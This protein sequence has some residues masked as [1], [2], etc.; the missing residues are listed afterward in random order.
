MLCVSTAAWADDTVTIEE[1]DYYFKVSGEDGEYQYLSRGGNWGTEAVI[2]EYGIGISVVL[3]SDGST[4]AFRDRDVYLASGNTRGF[5]TGPTSVY[6]DGDGGDG[7]WKFSENEDGTYYIINS[8]NNYVTFATASGTASYGNT[9][10]Y[11]YLSETSNKEDAYCFEL[12][13]EEKYATDLATRLD[14]YAA[15]VAEAAGLEDVSSVSSLETAVTGYNVSDYSSSITNAGYTSSSGWTFEQVNPATYSGTFD[16]SNGAFEIYGAAGKLYQTISD[17]PE[18]LYKVGVNAMQRQF[19]AS[20]YTTYTTLADV[21]DDL[22][23]LYAT[24]SASEYQTQVATWTSYDGYSSVSTIATFVAAAENYG[25]ALYVYVDD[26][27]SLTIGITQPDNS[28]YGAWTIATGWTLTRYTEAASVGSATTSITN[29]DILSAF[30]G[31]VTVKWSAS[32]STASLLSTTATATLTDSEG[33][34]IATGSISAATDGISVSFSDYTLTDY[35]TYTITIPDS[36]YGWSDGDQNTEV[37]VSFVYITTPEGDYYLRT[38]DEDGEYVYLSRGQSWS[39]CAVTDAYGIPFTTAN[40]TSGTTVY[41]ADMKAYLFDA[42]NGTVYTDNST[43][44]Y[45]AF[46][47][48]DDG[49]VLRNLNTTSNSTYGKYVSLTDDCLTITATS[50]EDA[51]VWVLED[52]ATHLEQMQAVDDANA[53]AVAAQAGLSGISSVSDLEDAVADYDTVHITLSDDYSNPTSAAAYETYQASPTQSGS[54]ATDRPVYPVNTQTV[55]LD[56]GLY[57]FSAQAFQRIS[58]NGTLDGGRNLVFLN[59]GGQST[60][61]MSLL[62]GPGSVT[63]RNGSNDYSYNGLYYAN[64]LTAAGVAFDSCEYTNDVWFYVDEDE[65][66]EVTLSLTI[67]VYQSTSNASWVCYRDYELTQ[68]TLPDSLSVTIGSGGYATLYYGDRDLTVAD[69]VTAYT[70]STVTFD[71]DEDEVGTITLN[72]VSEGVIPA[73]TAVVL[74]GTAG[75]Y[76]FAVASPAADSIAD[77]ILLGSDGGV[78][79]TDA[80]DEGHYYY[81]LGYSTDKTS[82]GFYYSYTTGHRLKVGAHKAYLQLD[83]DEDSAVKGFRFTTGTDEATGISNVNA[84]EAEALEGIYTLTG[85]RMAADDVEA[86]PTGLYIINGKKVLVK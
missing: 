47:P 32:D 80:D 1:G 43:Y 48:V 82:M 45:W 46:E 4:Y 52:F 60:Q 2:G 65:A 84:G 21:D 54:T 31:T 13:T 9:Y 25:N 57:K 6:A 15:A 42:N 83:A 29:N 75:T 12:L 7:S 44:P 53:A 27:E 63:Q 10:S 23:Y 20:Y 38:T 74:A 55:T 59:A 11:L 56:A 76:S 62:E 26:G 78:E 17:L 68:Y 5:L 67:E 39:T 22:S 66:G 41:F 77:N 18:G 33:E 30:D 19:P 3:N 71:N 72:E 34:T 51:T 50:A 16:T 35:E 79:I 73:G 61:V 69:S 40:T 58:W 64:D 24:T 81:V 14:K 8:N 37:S 70:A 86:L 49:Y 36:I 85:I 28:Y